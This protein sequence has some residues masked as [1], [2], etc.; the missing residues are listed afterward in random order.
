V[1]AEGA[2]EAV[3]VQLALHAS[4]RLRGLIIDR[5]LLP[6]EKIRQAAL[7][8]ELGLSRSPL[9][10][11]LRTLEAEGVLV[12]EANRGYVVARFDLED[13]IEIHR[14]REMFESALLCSIRPPTTHTLERLEAF[15]AE[16]SRGIDDEDVTVVL[17]ANREFHFEIFELSPLAQFKREA[18]RL[19]HLSEGYRTGWWQSEDLRARIDAEHVAMID[20]LREQDIDRLVQIGNVHRSAGNNVETA[21][22]YSKSARQHRPL[23]IE[24]GDDQV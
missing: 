23:S 2:V 15:N 16:M 14:M 11:A 22:L 20:A 4:A 12:H 8:A 19:W 1:V 18:H 24:L 5:V 3:P 17:R 7:A 6:G 10:E 13:L 9:R 21:V